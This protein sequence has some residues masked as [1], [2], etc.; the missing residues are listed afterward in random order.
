METEEDIN[1]SSTYH[2]HVPNDFG[3]LT[4]FLSNL[5]N[6]S[7]QDHVDYVLEHLKPQ[8]NQQIVQRTVIQRKQHDL[9]RLQPNLILPHQNAS[10]SPS[11]T[12]HNT[13]EQTSASRFENITNPVS[14]LQMY[15]KSMKHFPLKNFSVIR[16]H[17]MMASWAMAAP[18]CYKY[19][20]VAQVN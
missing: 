2:P 5:I 1:T 20:V 3:E 11:K 8:N 18:P 9:V 13:P 14:L 10:N 12:P 6:V 17:S 4:Q 16:R 15:L 7:H 19:I